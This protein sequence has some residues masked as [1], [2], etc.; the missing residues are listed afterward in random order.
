MKEPVLYIR[1][2]FVIQFPFLDSRSFDSRDHERL[3]RPYWVLP[4]PDKDFARSIGVITKRKRGGFAGW[5]GENY[6]CNAR[7]A[8]RFEGVPPFKIAKAS[9]GN[10]IK[11]IFRRLYFDGNALGRFEFGFYIDEARFNLLEDGEFDGIVYHF[12]KLRVRIANPRGE[13]ISSELGDSGKNLAKLFL[14]STTKSNSASKAED[15]ELV[16]NLK[17]MIT[18]VLGKTELDHTKIELWG[19]K[20]NV[21][22]D[23]FNISFYNAPYNRHNIPIWMFYD[24]DRIEARKLRVFLLRLHAEREGVKCVLRKIAHEKIQIDSRSVASDNLQNYLNKTTR[25]ILRIEAGA[26]D[27]LGDRVLNLARFALEYSTKGE[28]ASILQS[29]KELDLRKNIFNK[30]ERMFMEGAEIFEE[31]PFFKKLAGVT[32]E[33]LKE[34]INR[35]INNLTIG[36]IDLGLFDLFRILEKVIKAFMEELSSINP[37]LVAKKDMSTFANMI[38]FLKDKKLIENDYELNMLRSNRN[39]IV[40]DGMPNVTGRKQMLKR[41]YFITDLIIKYIFLFAIEKPSLAGGNKK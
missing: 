36:N 9:M 33:N 15:F 26:K 39:E 20:I 31:N 3:I 29:L 23:I 24:T 37:G 35:S 30:V 7:N 12:L 13:D 40:H 11:P 10:L 16:N 17:P 18:I 8:I 22:K 6:I 1:M 2:I 38:R 19:Q 32:D 28:T 25:E 21:E 4:E 14:L 41:A 27:L 34:N 5:V